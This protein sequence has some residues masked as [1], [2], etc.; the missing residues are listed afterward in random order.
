[1]S[2]FTFLEL[3]LDD[4]TI[5][6]NAPYSGAEPAEESAEETIGDDSGGV[7]VAALLVL[8]LVVSVVAALVARAVLGGDQPTD[9]IE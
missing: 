6:N 1:M 5:T 3:H 7:P 2:K 9:L 8:S 4:A